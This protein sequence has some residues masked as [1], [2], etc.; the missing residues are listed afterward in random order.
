M[1]LNFN[2][3][4][5]VGFVT[6]F[7]VLVLGLKPASAQNFDQ[8]YLNWKAQQQ[9]QDARLSSSNSDANYYL[10]KPSLTST[11]GNKIRLNSASAE[12]LQ[13]LSGIGEKKAEAILQY[14]QQHG[15]FKS[16]DELQNIKGIGPKLLQ[17]NK[18]R[19]AL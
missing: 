12:Q 14:R 7:I 4:R 2:A 17:K 13:Q 15:K 3:H 8:Q 18:D 1:Q 19:L 5:I 11:S 6:L 9:A 10:S 16:I